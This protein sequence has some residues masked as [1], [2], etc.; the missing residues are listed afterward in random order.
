M[1]K[2]SPWRRRLLALSLSGAL[3]FLAG[4]IFVRVAVGSPLPEQLPL[5]K[6]R[7]NAERG[8]EMLE[9][10]HWTYHH[11][12][13]VNRLGLRSRELAPHEEGELRVLV[14]GDSLVYGQG[15]GDLETL[16]HFLEEELRAGASG[17][18]SWTVVN[19]G[20]RAYD[21]RQELA[22]LESLGAEIDPDIVVLCWF[23][24]DLVERD[25]EGTYER[26]K[27]RGWLYFDTGS[28]LEGLESLRWHARELLRRSALVMYLHDLVDR[29]QVESMTGED[30]EAGMARLPGYMERFVSLCAS[31]DARPVFAVV[32]DPRALL[33][34]HSSHPVAERALEA[35]R[36]EGIPTVS[37]ERG[38][39]PH[40]AAGH[41]LPIIPFDGHYLPEGNRLMAEVLAPVVRALA[42]AA[43]PAPGRAGG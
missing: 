41:G 7:A 16:P 43:D 34:E 35:A 12:A 8:W 18:A 5:L 22:L 11:E 6:M 29:S 21:T 19:S 28:R 9:G 42:P 36:G 10:V 2:A 40:V 20:H 30:I 13:H 38:L 37:L 26:L 4:E 23:W 14:L 15:V 32:P 39:A 33:G 25:I 31:L 27:D 3:A 1:G 17:E 24:N